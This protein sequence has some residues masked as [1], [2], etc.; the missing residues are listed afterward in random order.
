MQE[1]RLNSYQIKD[2]KTSIKEEIFSPEILLYKK[3]LINTFLKRINIQK[4]KIKNKDFP[5][6]P[7]SKEIIL[8]E[9]DRVNYYIKNY[10][11]IRTRKIEKNILYIFQYDLNMLLSEGE[12]NYAVGF[13][14]ILTHQFKISF[15]DKVEQKFGQK[16]FY[17]K[18]LDKKGDGLQMRIVDKPN[19][20]K[21]VFVYFLKN[22]KNLA[23][24]K[25]VSMS[26]EQGD[27]VFV[28]FKFVKGIVESKQGLLI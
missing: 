12:F 9:L 24:E 14:K 18:L 10:L 2:L 17:N 11:R 13:Y 16:M 4:E 26:I 7:F 15:F 28:Q 21:Y 25:G 20:D 22:F 5:L 8:Y 3:E 1:E 23:L 19:T 6:S 27:I